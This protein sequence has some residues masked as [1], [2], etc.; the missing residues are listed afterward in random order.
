MK[1]ILESVEDNDD[2]ENRPQEYLDDGNIGE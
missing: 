2:D 1:E